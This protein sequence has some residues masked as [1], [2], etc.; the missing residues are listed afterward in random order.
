LA[1]HL[2]LLDLIILITSDEA[3]KLWS[4]S[5]RSFLLALP[6]S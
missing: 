1:A 6:F 2:S 4:S 5:L 3:Y